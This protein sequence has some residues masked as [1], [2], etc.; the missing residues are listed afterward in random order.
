MWATLLDEGTYLCSIRTMYRILEE[1]G[2]VRERRNQRRHPNYT[3]PELLAEA[4]NQVWSWDITKL[5]GPVKWTYYYLYVILDIFSRYV[6]GWMLAHRE[7][8]A[9]AQRL[10]AE[11]CRKQDIEPDQLTLHADRGSSMRSKPVALLLADLGVTKTHSRPYVSNDNPYSESQFKTMKYCPQFPSRFGS[12]EDGRLFCGGF[13]DYYNYEHRHSGIGFMTPADVH[14]GRAEQL[15]TARR[16]V[17]LEA[18]RTHPERFVRGTPQPPVLPPGLD[19]PADGENDAPEC[20]TSHSRGGVHTWGT[21]FFCSTKRDL[22]RCRC[23]P[24]RRHEPPDAIRGSLNAARECLKVVDTYRRRNLKNTKFPLLKAKHNRSAKDKRVLRE[25]VRANRRLYRA[26]LL[27]DDFMDL[28]TYKTETWA[29]KFLRGWLRRAMSSRIEPVKRAA[30]M[31][32][33]HFDGVIA[34]VTWR[35]SNGRLVGMN[36]KIRLLSHRSFG[37]HSA[38]ALI[39]L[40]YLNCGGLTLERIH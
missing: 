26:M 33:S 18:H 10:I 22:D 32:R 28:Y 19:Q 38:E 20:R 11:S 39:S 13:F 29:K 14:Y 7:S 21:P 24:H 12:A 31:I 6:V 3:K 30:K 35:L 34:W 9:L 17:L 16:Q 15:T 27:R 4:P 5:R 25:Q 37:L 23:G 36:N 1:H 8:A 2:E 40:V